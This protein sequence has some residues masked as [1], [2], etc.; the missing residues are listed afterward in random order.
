[1]RDVV[2][3]VVV[4]RV[5][6]RQH[7]LEG[8]ID[9]AVATLQQMIERT[10]LRHVVELL[11][12]LVGVLEHAGRYQVAKS[13]VEGVHKLHSTDSRAAVSALEVWFRTDRAEED[14]RTATAAAEVLRERTRRD[15]LTGLWNREYLH[16]LA[17]T[18]R[19]VEGHQ[20][21][22]VDIDGFKQLNDSRGHLAG[23]EAL[24]AIARALVEAVDPHDI[25]ARF[26]GDEF[27]V[28]RHADQ[29]GSLADDLGAFLTDPVLPEHGVSASIG[30]VRS[31]A[32]G[33]E[34][35]LEAAD[36]C[37]YRAKR[38]GGRRIFTA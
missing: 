5:Q 38:A 6:A 34:S 25:T 13:Q 20:I 14:A 29:P 2:N 24:R 21:A 16:Q 8:R 28:I 22:V 4:V 35:A 27:V 1:M 11:G 31:T 15:I 9:E 32:E 18:Q 17:L 36:A 23:D 7:E 37:M 3:A 33:F 19:P 12:T 26:G 30:V 10:P